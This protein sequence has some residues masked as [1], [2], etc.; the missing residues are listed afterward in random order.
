LADRSVNERQLISLEP[1]AFALRISIPDI[2]V[3][4]TILCRVE[5]IL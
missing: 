1:P 5:E 2:V 3:N 4:L